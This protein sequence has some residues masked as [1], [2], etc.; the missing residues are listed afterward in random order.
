MAK[1]ELK[2]ITSFDTLMKQFD[3]AHYQFKKSDMEMF[4][5]LLKDMKEDEELKLL[6][7]RNEWDS[8]FKGKEEQC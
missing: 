2:G 5:V 8:K 3:D 1:Y 6:F 7:S 4:D